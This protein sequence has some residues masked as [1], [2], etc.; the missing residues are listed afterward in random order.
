MTGEKIG[1]ILVKIKT[2]KP[3]KSKMK[4]ADYLTHIT[5]RRNRNLKFF[6]LFVSSMDM[7]CMR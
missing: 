4:K 7:R 3:I 5:D 1:L 6:S 2:V